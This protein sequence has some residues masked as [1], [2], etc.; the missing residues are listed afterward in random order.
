MTGILL[1][2]TVGLLFALGGSAL[3]AFAKNRHKA[4]PINP[5]RHLAT[6]WGGCIALVCLVLFWERRPLSSIGIRIGDFQTWGIAALLGASIVLLSGLSLFFAKK[7]DMNGSAH[8]A[9]ALLR[10]AAT[11]LW[12]RVGAVFTAGIT[13]EVIFRGY[14]IERLNEMTGSL[15]L[16]AL[17]PLI[18]FTLS[19][20]GAW[21]VSH[22]VSVFFGGVVLTAL[23]LWRH[24]LIACMIAHTII[25]VPI[26]FLPLHAKK[27]AAA[28]KAQTESSGS[29]I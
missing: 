17:V 23:Y 11:P 28:V 29:A 25:D 22:L 6:A 10:L 12:F 9:S 13:E 15:W 18:I 3:L 20:L 24:D 27:L 14:P 1:S 2:S 16:A 21:P 7:R 19:H 4:A 26:I 5:V 8:V